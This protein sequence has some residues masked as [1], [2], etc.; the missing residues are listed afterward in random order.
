MSR[1]F[2][3]MNLLKRFNSICFE[4]GYRLILL[5]M[6]GPK[7]RTLRERYEARLKQLNEQDDGRDLA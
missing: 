2:T 1:G 5:M 6:A 7:P 4:I 3:E